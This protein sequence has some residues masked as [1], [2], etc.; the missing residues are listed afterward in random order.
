MLIKIPGKPI[1]LQR[2]RRGKNFFYDPQFVVKKNI[3]EY[4]KLD[5]EPFEDILEVDFNFFF[6]IP[7]SWSKKKKAAKLNTPHDQTPDLD[8]IIKFI[9]DLFNGIVWKDDKIIFKINA[10]KL[11][12]EKSQ[13]IVDINKYGSIKQSN[14]SSG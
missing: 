9:L 6:E 13:T 5:M 2:A 14:R 3:L 11:W 1:P 4:L 12:S 7:Q 10:E 8:N